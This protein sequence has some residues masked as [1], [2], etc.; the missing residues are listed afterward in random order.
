MQQLRSFLGFLPSLKAHCFAART[1]K[2]LQVSSEALFCCK[3]GIVESVDYEEDI[4]RC[5]H[6]II[7]ECPIF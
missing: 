6:P 3:M 1:V 4:D 2:G 5:L 7:R